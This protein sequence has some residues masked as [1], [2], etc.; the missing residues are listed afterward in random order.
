VYGDKESDSTLAVRER[1]GEQFTAS[2][3]ELRARLD[4]LA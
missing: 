3:D 4:G 1:G 2:L